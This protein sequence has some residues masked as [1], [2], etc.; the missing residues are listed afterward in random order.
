MYFVCFHD[1]N[2]VALLKRWYLLL[3]VPLRL[4][5]FHDR[6]IVALLKRIPAFAA[7]RMYVLVSTIEISWLY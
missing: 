2:I 1:R 3:A 4:D 7:L 5:S 6:N